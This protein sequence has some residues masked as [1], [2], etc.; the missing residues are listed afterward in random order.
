MISVY[1]QCL[2]SVFIISVAVID[3]LVPICNA[4]WTNS[5]QTADKCETYLPEV[6]LFCQQRTWMSSVV[7]ITAPITQAQTQTDTCKHT[8]VTPQD[9]HTTSSLDSSAS[10]TDRP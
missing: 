8:S 1:D 5:K 7:V 4:L 6:S 9:T 2:S 3:Y 10:Q